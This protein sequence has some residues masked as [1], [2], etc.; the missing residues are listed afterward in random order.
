MTVLKAYALRG[1]ERFLAEHGAA[2]VA[3]LERVLD[4]SDAAAAAVGEGA[5]PNA[6]VLLAVVAAAELLMLLAPQVGRPS[7]GRK[8]KRKESR[9]SRGDTEH[10]PRARRSRLPPPLESLTARTA[11]ARTTRHST[12]P[13]RSRRACL[14]ASRP[15]CSA[16]RTGTTRARR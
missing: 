1:A 8:V 10:T 6:V 13:T 5:R 3:A 14:R 4:A 9:V 7:L 16:T 12:R 2:L 11:R 15:S